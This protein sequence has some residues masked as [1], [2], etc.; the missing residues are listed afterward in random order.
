[1]KTLVALALVALYSAV[2]QQPPRSPDRDYVG[3]YRWE[4]GSFVYLQNWD[5]FGGLVALDDSGE[6]RKLYPTGSDRFS[7]GAAI[8]VPAPVESQ[9]EFERDRSGSIA[10]LKWSRAGVMR[11]GRRANIETRE[12]VRFAN[13]PVRLAGSLI[14][15]VAPG[16]HPAIVLVHGSGPE[17]RDYVLPFAHFLVRRGI[18]LLAYEKRGVGGS[19][20]DWNTATFEDLAAD[21]VA[22]FE[23]LKTRPD[24][25]ARRIGLLGISQAGWIMPLAAVREPGIAFLISVSGAGVS[26]AETTIDEARNEMASAGTPPQVIAQVTALMQLQY[27]YAKTGE[28]WDEYRAARDPLAARMGPSKTFPATAD[29]PQWDT[30]RR[31]YFYDPAPVLRRLRTPTLALFGELD[32]NIVAGKNLAAWDSALKAAGNPYYAL[33]VLP[34][35]DHLLLQ[36]KTGSNAEMPS[37]QRLVPEYYKTLD[38]WLVSHVGSIPR[39]K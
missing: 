22:A 10:A 20:G 16:R 31:W 29:D 5:E 34:K 1:M 32:D 3:V 2:A 19:T 21:V 26:P 8:A 14:S 23:F 12:E 37:L 13:G 17:D 9:I 33:R 30:L 27:R 36:A 24:I 15:P 38:D 35:A 39:A 25:D 4:D 7:T 28:G 6:L 18:A 11:I